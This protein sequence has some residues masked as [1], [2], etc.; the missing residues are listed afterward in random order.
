M[1]SAISSELE[2]NISICRSWQSFSIPVGTT[3]MQQRATWP[4]GKVRGDLFPAPCCLQT[5]S[6][7][8]LKSREKALSSLRSGSCLAG[9]PAVCFNYELYTSIR[10]ALSPLLALRLLMRNL[11]QL[12]LS[13]RCTRAAVS[14]LCRRFLARRSLE[15]SRDALFCR[16]AKPWTRLWLPLKA[17]WCFLAELGWQN[18]EVKGSGFL[19]LQEGNVSS[20]PISPGC[21]SFSASCQL[22]SQERLPS[23]VGLCFPRAG[24]Q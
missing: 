24:V 17:P 16:A 3:R 18:P 4:D 22:S 10:F 19:G 1:A 20:H 7:C 14:G 5:A 13:A 6:Y 9:A 15:V 11:V 23:L 12:S 2:S 8:E 21:V